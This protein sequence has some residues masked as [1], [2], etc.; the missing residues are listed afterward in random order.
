MPKR[1]QPHDKLFK[2]TL[3]NPRDAAL[4]L[5]AILPPALAANIDFGSLAPEP[6]TFLDASIKGSYADLLY[7]VR[8]RGRKALLYVLLE[9][10][11]SPHRFTLL[12]LLRYMIRIWEK[13]LAR[14]PKPATLPPIIPV[15]VYHSDKGRPPAT[16]FHALFAPDLMS[17]PEL[18][19]LTPA[20]EARLDDI[21]RLSDEALRA[22]TLG[23]QATL[24][25]VFLRDGRRKGRVLKELANWADLYRTLLA[26]PEGQRAILQL[27]SYLSMVAPHLDL[28]E[29]IQQVHQD[30]PETETLVMTLAEKLLKQGRQE[31]RKEGSSSIVRRQI[32]LKFGPLAPSDLA[33]LDAADEAALARYA[34]RVLTATS[35]EDVLVD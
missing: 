32:E 12:Q 20:F 33:R 6:D 31:G 13:H 3:G 29:F 21:S 18:A 16:H 30:I 24:G 22:R 19:R 1:D 2:Q 23:P 10:K 9:H 28:E 14:T 34:D 25:L 27:F 5:R 15:I 7:T 8:Y 17:D 4:E 26:T 11:S 35:V